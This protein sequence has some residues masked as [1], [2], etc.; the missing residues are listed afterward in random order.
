MTI[1]RFPWHIGIA[2]DDLAASMEA[3]GGIF[4]LGW[5]EVRTGQTFPLCGPDG[6]VPD[7]ADRVV[8]IGG[9]LRIELLQGIADSVWAPHRGPHLHHYAY[10]SDDVAGDVGTLS[11][12]GWSIELTTYDAGGRPVDFAY[13]VNGAGE[14]MELVNDS[15]RPGYLALFEDR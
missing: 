5:S 14:R 7:T 15:L 4:G 12:Q 9:A 13:L 2:T 6:P 8:S 11:V 3:L 10:W 1:S